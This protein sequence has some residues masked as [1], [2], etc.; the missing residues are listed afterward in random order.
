MVGEENL[1][2]GGLK[3]ILNGT[4]EEKGLRGL[5]RKVQ[6]LEG[7]LKLPV[8]DNKEAWDY[9]EKRKDK[10][11][12]SINNYEGKYSKYFFKMLKDIEDRKKCALSY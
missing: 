3:I 12:G 4:K 6:G 1:F 5:G 7:T 11:E 2:I 10:F 8:K 9:F